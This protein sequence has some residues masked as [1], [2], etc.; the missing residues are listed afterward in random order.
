MGG[1]L[2]KVCCLN[3]KI[4]ITEKNLSSEQS[5]SR[6][7]S[8]CCVKT[9]DPSNPKSFYFETFSELDDLQNFSRFSF[10][11]NLTIVPS[12]ES[13]E[14]INSNN[15]PEFIRGFRRSFTYKT[16]GK[17][18]YLQRAKEQ[19]KRKR[20]L[21]DGNSSILKTEQY[22]DKSTLSNFKSF[23]FENNMKTSDYV[24]KHNGD[25]GL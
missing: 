7:S 10:T 5:H 22:I 4:L 8:P 23:C 25:I 15:D 9:P 13:N 1:Y 2:D 6:I 21:N 12:I 14:K 11:R 17:T 20:S 16:P 3:T 19:F 18:S 24:E